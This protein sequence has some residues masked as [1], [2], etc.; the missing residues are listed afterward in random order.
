MDAE[1]IFELQLNLQMNIR[2]LLFSLSCFGI[3][4]S[5]CVM[6]QVLNAQP[7]VQMDVGKIPPPYIILNNSE[8]HKPNYSILLPKYKR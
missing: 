8:V 1:A 7:K 5:R 6:K 2:K 3:L 4:L